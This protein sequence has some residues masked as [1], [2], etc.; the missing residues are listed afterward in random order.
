[1]AGHWHHRT[2]GAALVAGLER[3]QVGLYLGAMAIGVVVGLR[4]D[5]ASG[6]DVAITPVLALLLYATFLGV[7]F[8][9]IRTTLTDGRF[10]RAVLVLN[11]LVAPLVVLALSRAVVSDGAL[12]VGVLLVLLTP[13]I[14]YVIVFTRLAGGAADRLLAVAPVLLVLQLLL[15]PLYLWVLAGREVASMVEPGPFLHALVVLIVLPLL[16]AALTQRLADRTRAGARVMEVMAALMV[17]LM[18]LTLLVVIASQ[19]GA[20]QERLGAV[21]GV[22]PV[23]VAYAVVMVG[24]GVLVARGSRLDV[25]GSRAVVLSGVTRNS[26]VVLPLA[27]ALP[28]ELALVPLVVVSQTLVELLVLVAALRLVPR[29]LPATSAQE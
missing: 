17:P 9:R 23:F 14:D 2:S 5:A 19:V 12:L 22:L 7:P 4:V 1:M 28:A 18:M 27:L 24:A 11:F 25:E 6:L 29:L 10:L 15:L 20:V 26:L 8:S 13:C 21:L 3:R 16:A